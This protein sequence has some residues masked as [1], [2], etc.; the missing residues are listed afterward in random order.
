VVGSQTILFWEGAWLTG[1]WTTPEG[2]PLRGVAVDVGSDV[3]IVVRD[4]EPRAVEEL[5]PDEP[6]EGSIE[7]KESLLGGVVDCLDAVGDVPWE[8]VVPDESA[9][10]FSRAFRLNLALVSAGI[11]SLVQVR[12]SV[13]QEKRTFRAF[14]SPPIVLT[15]WA[16]IKE[17]SDS[18]QKQ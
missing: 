17:L 15:L 9:L 8:V 3:W 13:A 7:V 18:S 12:H 4:G 2:T 5:I 11:C 14:T 6:I 1:R 10:G 16:L